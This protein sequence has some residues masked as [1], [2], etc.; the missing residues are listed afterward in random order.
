MDSPSRPHTHQA[1]EVNNLGALDLLDG[2]YPEA[3]SAFAQAI[4]AAASLRSSG[5]CS[6]SDD[7][8]EPETGQLQIQTAGSGESI[9]LD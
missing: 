3:I 5:A 2:K 1:A 9:N 4:E 6:G 7:H 8:D